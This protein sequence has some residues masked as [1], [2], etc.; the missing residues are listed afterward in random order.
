[1]LRSD[2]MSYYW[3]ICYNPLTAKSAGIEN[4]KKAVESRF[5]SYSGFA[6]IFLTN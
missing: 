6:S 1:M 4:Q 5:T 2:W 3:A